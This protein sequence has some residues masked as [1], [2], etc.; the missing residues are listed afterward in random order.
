MGC[1][2]KKNV[3]QAPEVIMST[4][5]PAPINIPQTP[6]EL[7]AQEITQWNGGIQIEEKND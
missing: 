6:E 4:P 3:R 5:T 7:H 1:N 2:C